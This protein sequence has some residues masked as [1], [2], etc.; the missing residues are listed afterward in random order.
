M[1]IFRAHT[2]HRLLSTGVWQD[3][4]ESSQVLWHH[5]HLFMPSCG[6]LCSLVDGQSSYRKG[7]S[8]NCCRQIFQIILVCCSIKDYFTGTKKPSPNPG[9]QSHT[10]IPS[11]SSFTLDTTQS[12]KCRSPGNCQTLTPSSDC[13]ME[14]RDLAFHSDPVQWRHALHHCIQR[15]ALF[16]LD[17]AAGLP[18]ETHY[19]KLS[20]YC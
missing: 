16:L 12:D 9:E 19:M 11:A 18:M 8:P 1:W 15:F 2:P 10:I 6:W 4:V 5:T 17:D 7:S 3:P 13:Q 20:V 14:R